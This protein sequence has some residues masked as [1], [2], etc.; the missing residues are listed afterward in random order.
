MLLR[1]ARPVIGIAITV[2][3][4]AAALVAGFHPGGATT[5]AAP[6]TRV[7]GQ[8]FERGA[9]EHP[10][11]PE[12]GRDGAA[13]AGPPAAAPV[14]SA[15][16]P[17]VDLPV[18]YADPA[19]RRRPAARRPAPSG[20][21]VWAVVV[22]I[23]DYPGERYDLRA[24]VADSRQVET[25]LDRTGTPAGQRRILR[26][27]QATAAQVL[28][29]LDWL[30]ANAGPQATAVVF[31]AGHARSTDGHESLVTSGGTLIRDTL[32][33]ERLAPLAARRTWVAISACF[34]GGFTEVLAPGRILTG[35]A[36]AGER[37][38]ETTAYDASYLV[39]F[40]VRRALVGQEASG[41]LQEAFAW[42]RAAIERDHPGRVPVQFEQDAAGFTLAARP[43]PASAPPAKPAP[44]PAG[45]APSSQPAPSGGS[46]P[47]PAP[48]PAPSPSDPNSC[49]T[50]T[51]GAVSCGP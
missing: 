9:A 28:D 43:Q 15:V 6:P 12:S 38:Y 39:E 51:L 42:T 23:D 19:P 8:V 20:T 24:A 10:A 21:G 1:R 3:L 7:L 16:E 31:F 35:A 46:G 33:A 50:L 11:P 29:A 37:A 44:A 18:V 25:L 5:T 13:P 36:P 41:S 32:L 34:G 27:G 22:G 47:A 49:R 30:V 17:P 26:D 45:P 48:A 2:A 14:D 4:A 40:M